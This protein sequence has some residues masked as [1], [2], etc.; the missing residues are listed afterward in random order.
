MT[1]LPRLKVSGAI[2]AKPGSVRTRRGARERRGTRSPTIAPPIPSGL[3]KAELGDLRTALRLSREPGWN[4]VAA[5]WRLM[6][7]V[8]DSFGLASNENRLVAS[9]LTVPFRGQFGWISMI[10]VTAPFR[11]RGLATYLMGRCIAALRARGLV[12]ALD[13]TPEGRTVYRSLG[14][15]DVYPITR[16]LAAAPSVENELPPPG[17]KVRKMSVADLAAVNAYDTPIFGADRRFLIEHLRS[18]RPA[19][20]FLATRG[21]TTCGYVLAREGRASTQIGPLV[22]DDRTTALA[23][24]AR[25]LGANS[26]PVC[27]DLLDRHRAVGK[28]LES[29]GFAPLL[30]FIRMIHGRSEPFDDVRRVFAI[31]GPELG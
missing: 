5:D 14:F 1:G 13:A 10:L 11:R 18:R 20:A 7:K 16:F 8:G 29:R 26:G 12:P 22:A 3:K 2:M 28:E 31:A 21:A 9:G 25:S 15:R 30:R 6:L 27:L 23:L 4:Q 17:V 24:L 19:L